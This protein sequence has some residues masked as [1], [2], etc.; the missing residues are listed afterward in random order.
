MGVN[1]VSESGRSF[2]DNEWF[3]PIHHKNWWG[4]GTITEL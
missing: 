3:T 4:N 2:A 1:K